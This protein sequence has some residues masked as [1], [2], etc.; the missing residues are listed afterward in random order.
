MECSFYFEV[1]APKGL[2]A[3]KDEIDSS[4]L[5]LY[6]YLSGFNN[7]HILKNRIESKIDI[8]MDTS[9]ID[10]M[11]ASGHIESDFNTAKELMARLSEIFKTAGYPHKIGIDD[12]NGENTVWLTSKYS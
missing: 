8:G 12:E 9:T 5:G 6:V 10:M 3:I 2:G 1:I 11:H 7:K 4:G